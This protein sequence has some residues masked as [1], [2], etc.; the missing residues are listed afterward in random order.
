MCNL[1]ATKPLTYATRRLKAGDEFTARSVRDARIL[2]AI[3]KAR[4]APDRAEPAISLEE[5]REAYRSLKQD[6]PDKRWGVAR[7]EREL[8]IE[9]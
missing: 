7:L 2:I 6:E 8:G 3:R 5:L 4:V 1:I 9:D